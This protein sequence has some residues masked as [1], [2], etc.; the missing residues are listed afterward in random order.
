VARLLAETKLFVGG[1]TGPTLV[2]VGYFLYRSPPFAFAKLLKTPAVHI[3]Q[4]GTGEATPTL[5]VGGDEGASPMK[6]RYLVGIAIAAAFALY[7]GAVIQFVRSQSDYY[8]PPP[9]AAS[10][11][12]LFAPCQA[13]ESAMGHRVSKQEAVQ[14][15]CWRR[16]SGPSLPL[17]W[18][19]R[20]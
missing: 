17:S 20:E 5:S 18:R 12:T 15:G 16:I 9:S 14:M 8:C 10:V 11:A 2:P 3:H 13:F 19:T 4:C 1:A 6:S 7:V